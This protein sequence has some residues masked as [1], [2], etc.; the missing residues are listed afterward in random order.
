MRFDAFLVDHPAE[1]LRGPVSR[2][3]DEP[4]GVR[5]NRASTRSTITL[6][7]ATSSVRFAGVASTSRMTP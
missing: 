4:L 3:T 5:S 2:V 6:V 1:Q 7:D